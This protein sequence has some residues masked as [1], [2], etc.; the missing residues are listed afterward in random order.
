MKNFL[1]ILLIPCFMFLGACDTIPVVKQEHVI[2]K[3]IEY[4][5]KIPPAELLTLPQ[6]TE[7]INVDTA[8][9]STIAQWI[10]SNEERIRALENMLKGIAS[11]FTIEQLKLR[12]LAN[13]KNAEALVAASKAD[14]KFATNVIGTP[15]KK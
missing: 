8:T 14:A 12:E 11:F 3:Q 5:V 4:V 7:K 9:Q 2:V 10:L 1:L 15:V 6:Q 13:T